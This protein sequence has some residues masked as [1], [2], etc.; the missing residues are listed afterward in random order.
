MRPWLV[1]S[2][3][4]AGSLPWNPM[5]L[6]AK[7]TVFE[8][9]SLRPCADPLGVNTTCRPLLCTSAIHWLTALAAQL[10]PVNQWI[11]D[12]QSNGLQVV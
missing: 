10:E 8:A 9:K 2:A 5:S 11:A 3:C 4:V 12:V 6:T 7:S 1:S